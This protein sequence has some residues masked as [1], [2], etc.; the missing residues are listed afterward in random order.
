VAAG[1]RVVAIT[2]DTASVL[3]TFATAHQIA[4]PLLSDV[5]GE[6]IQAFGLLN[7]NIPPNPR[8]ATG[9]PFPGHF[10]V[11]PDGRVLAKAFTGDL[12]HR[13]SGSALVL[14]F[15]G[16]T[17]EAAITIANDVVTARITLSSTRLFG[18][19]EI[20]VVVDLD[21]ADRWHVYA[22]SVSVPYTPL[23]IH[24]D[25]D[26][27]LLA[28]QRFTMPAPVQ[29]DFAATGESLPVH[30]GHVRVSGRARLRWSPP[31]S[32]FAGLEEAVSRRAIVP[33]EY[34][35]RGTLR[36]QACNESVC[37]EPRVERFELP[38]IV[39]ANVAPTPPL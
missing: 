30:K 23:S 24:I 33:G 32:M 34:R 5:G 11:A 10:F 15:A 1:I 18:G 13:V 29:L 4:Y 3:S 25:T 19:Q 7:P 39:E 26:G 21:I 22:E 36:Y 6:V 27:D 8:Q 37:L 28:M 2:P 14:E 17:D 12:R 35:L 31:P 20:A 38:I 16:V 9:Q